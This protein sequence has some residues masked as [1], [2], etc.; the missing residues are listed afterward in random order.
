MSFIVKQPR[1]NGRIHLFLAESYRVESKAYPV[2]KRTYLG[3]LD[4]AA[5][6]LLL[7]RNANEPSPE[8]IKLLLGRKP[9][10]ITSGRVLVFDALKMK[11]I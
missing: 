7:A 8:V 1:S 5:T 3:V 6:E 11:Y 9:E 10:E 4:S 2:Q